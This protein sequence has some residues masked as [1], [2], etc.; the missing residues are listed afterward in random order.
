MPEHEEEAAATQALSDSLLP[1]WR[2]DHQ[3]PVKPYFLER[4]MDAL[5]PQALEPD[6]ETRSTFIQPVDAREGESCSAFTDR[7]SARQRGGPWPI[8]WGVRLR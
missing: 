7:H 5:H 1:D 8:R 6:H 2:T 3:R 4:F